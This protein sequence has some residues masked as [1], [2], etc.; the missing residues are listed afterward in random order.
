M[1]SKKGVLVSKKSIDTK[2]FEIVK[3]VAAVIGVIARSKF[4]GGGLTLADLSVI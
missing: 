2:L 1:K 4:A 3:G